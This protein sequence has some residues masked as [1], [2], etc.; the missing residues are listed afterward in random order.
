MLFVGF[1]VGVVGAVG[2]TVAVG[3]IVG[4]LFFSILL[5]YVLRSMLCVSIAAAV[6][7]PFK[8]KYN[9]LGLFC[10]LRCAVVFVKHSHTNTRMRS[11]QTSTEL[12]DFVLQPKNIQP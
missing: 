11:I 4:R 3:R 12:N 8:G 10:T 2:V 7:R 6:Y 1:V 9:C 5:S